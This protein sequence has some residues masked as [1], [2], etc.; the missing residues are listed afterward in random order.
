[1]DGRVAGR[2]QRSTRVFY[3]GL[4][5]FAVSGC[6]AA[7]LPP[8]EHPLMNEGVTP[9]KE[10]TLGGDLVTLPERGKV[11]VVDFWSTSCS[12][13]KELMPAIEALYE[14]EQGEGVKVVGV[15]VDDN[16]GL[17]QKRARERG[18]TYPTVLDAE[19]QIE[20]AYRVTDLPQTFVFDR[21]GTLRFFAKGGSGAEAAKIRDAVDALVA[22]P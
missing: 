2:S 11:T 12:S 1:M 22:E 20:G 8:S 9:R 10:E 5:A 17:V 13:C 4:A 18:V 14:K 7:T 16:P 21:K 15:A 6:G 3:A 19:S